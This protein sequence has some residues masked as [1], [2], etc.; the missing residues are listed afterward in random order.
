[1]ATHLDIRP[2]QPGDEAAIIELFAQCFQRPLSASWWDW[3]FRDNPAGHALIELAWDGEQLVGHHAVS[4]VYL[5]TN[6]G[7]RVGGLSGTTMTHPNYGAHGLFLTLAGRV[8]ERMNNAGMTM[9]WGFPNSL[10]HRGFIQGLQWVD[11]Y[12]IP[13]FRLNL[14]HCPSLPAVRANVVELLEFDQ[15]F[16]RLW[17]QIRGTLRFATRRD[18]RFLQWRYCKHPTVPYRL[19]A[20]IDGEGGTIEGYAVLKSYGREIQIVDLLTGRDKNIGRQLVLQAMHLALE[21]SAM[22]VSMWLPI[23]H[24]LHWTLERMGFKNGSPV[25]YFAGLWLQDCWDRSCYDFRNW[26]CTAGDSDVF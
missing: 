4:P 16:D 12:E 20:Y 1:M 18:C 10:S 15:R 14:E 19:L 6:Q 13:M 11:I 26:Y 21:D 2:Y 22:G 23:T 7:E 17:E 3:W 9:V 24:P 5:L 8:Y 25:T